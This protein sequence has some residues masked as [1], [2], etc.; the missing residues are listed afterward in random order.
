MQRI[1]RDP[2]QYDIIRLLDSFGRKQGVSIQDP[3]K[4]SDFFSTLASAITLK[5][6]AEHFIHGQRVEKMFG[7][8]AASLGACSLIKEEDIGE[9]YNDTEDIQPPDY[10]ICLKDGHVI[11][12]EVKNCH[13][14]SGQFSINES[15]LIALQNYS[16]AFN[17]ELWLAVYWSKWNMWVMID[18]SKMTLGKT[19]RSISLGESLKINNM[20]LLG[21]EM[22]GTT[23]PLAFRV[24]SNPEEVRTI[25][26]NGQVEFTIGAIECYCGGNKIE[27]KLETN[28]AFYLVLFGGW[29]SKDP[30]AKIE[31]GKL[32][33]FEFIAEPE[34]TEPGQNFQM[35]GSLSSMISRRY[36]MLT[37][38]DIGV[39]R[40]APVQEPGTLGV[41]IPVDYKGKQL[42]LWRFIIKPQQ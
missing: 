4:D 2:E 6:N 33:H 8:V 38:D 39:T 20:F 32:L 11:Y 25:D 22:I 42:R 5:R 9:V 16:K 35:L 1:R 41:V 7:Y 17:R 14:Q 21:D 13:K 19:R 26:G 36:A 28:L 12:V 24:L 18:P 29:P 23:P 40:L 37:T 31:D 30:V 15:D 27:E 10:K 34:S 3:K